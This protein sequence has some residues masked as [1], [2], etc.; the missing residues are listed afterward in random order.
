MSGK[1]I[2]KTVP[3]VPNKHAGGRQ[4][5]LPDTA[6]IYQL[7]V[8]QGLTYPEIASM[9]GVT[10]Q[11]VYARLHRLMQHLPNRE[12]VEVYKKNKPAI[13]HAAELRVLGYMLD[14]EKLQK[15]SLNNIP[16]LKFHRGEGSKKARAQ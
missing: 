5:V 14:D 10:K 3:T 15:A 1:D 2:G 6:K 9:F 13:L 7:R 4:S 11:A 12:Q 8:E 16:I